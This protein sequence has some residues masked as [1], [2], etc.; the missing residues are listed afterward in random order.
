MTA[1]AHIANRN[2]VGIAS[3]AL[4][5]MIFSLQD[6]ILKTV[7]GD[8]AV[9]LAIFIRC[10]V[11]IPLLL[12]M[13][14]I[15]VG[16][17]RLR[18]R[19]LPILLLRGLI[20]LAAYTSYYMALPALPLAEAVALFFIAPVI[21]TIL[22][23]P[24]L[25]EHV[26]LK[27]WIAV[28]AGFAGVLIILQPGSALFEPAALLSVISAGTYAL[29]AVLA[30]RLGVEEPAT[31]MAFYQNFVFMLGAGVIAVIFNLSG[32]ERLG[33][34]SLDFLV[35]P[36]AMPGLTDFLLMAACGV[37]AA[38][39]TFLLTNAYR[40]AQANVVTVFEYTGMI[41]GPLWGFLFF[42]EVPRLTTVI[43]TIVIIAAGIFAVRSA[44][45]PA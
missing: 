2:L 34:P 3:L 31:V 7:S 28:V 8:H 11:A 12:I 16:L 5:V 6:A 22:S 4:G 9:T 30:R 29:S 27:S 35:R 40:M 43:G 42:A 25:G 20:L 37:I 39:A 36:W 24:M 38:V 10:L 44:K 33:H 32:V 15:E 14:Q 1:T 19:N 21:V 41:W 18:S 13:V 26:S 45:S 23:G 17:R